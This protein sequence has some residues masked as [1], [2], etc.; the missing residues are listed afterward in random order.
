[1][2][3]KIK[4]QQKSSAKHLTHFVTVLTLHWS[5]SVTS[6]SLLLKINF[7]NYLAANVEKQAVGRGSVR[8]KANRQWLELDQAGFVGCGFTTANTDSF[9][10]L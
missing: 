10:G 2:N 8:L 7:Q 6:L 9:S 4:Q 3:L 1:M 5:K